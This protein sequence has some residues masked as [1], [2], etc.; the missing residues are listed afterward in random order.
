MLSSTDYSNTIFYKI[1]CKDVNIPDV[2]VGHTTDFVQRKR[3]HKN[4]CHNPSY[5]VYNCKLYTTIRRLGGWDNWNM[6][7]IAFHKC[8][9][10]YDARKREQEY[11]VSLGATLNSIE[12]LP[13]P[14][15]KPLPV[16]NLPVKS[17]HV[18]DACN[19][20]CFN[21]LDVF[22]LHF[23]S[24]KHLKAVNNVEKDH[25]K[26]YCE[27]CHYDTHNKKDYNKHLL[28]KKHIQLL[29][30][31]THNKYKCLNCDKT[32]KYHSGIWKHKQSC[33]VNNLPGP[34][35]NPPLPPSPP[36]LHDASLVMELIKQNQEFKELM[37]LQSKQL[38]EQ[39]LHNT[40]LLEAVI[41][42]RHAN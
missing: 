22:N 11:F 35:E 42:L 7:I 23:T 21:T 19:Y 28:T 34:Y 8:N 31:F 1:Y 6:D 25:A 13:T 9:D 14:A 5:P 15:E 39:Q 18:C 24:K 33:V 12:P 41:P 37:M 30:E 4:S 20:S 26:Y 27:K 32:Y 40:L 3:A 38:A 10:Q 29:E 16:A 2:Y 17:R 36:Q